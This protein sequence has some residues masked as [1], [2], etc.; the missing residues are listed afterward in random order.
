MRMS[1]FAVLSAAAAS[2]LTAAA[3]ISGVGTAVAA[4][5]KPAEVAVPGSSPAFTAHARVIGNV[6]TTRQLSIQFWLKPRSTA[7][8][9][10]A[11]A[12]STPG[13]ALFHHYLSPDQYTARFGPTAGQA[14][15]VE[16][17]LRG[18][19]F[20]D[21]Q[22]DAQRDYV[23]ATAP[24]ATINR[25]LHVT[26]KL[27][28]PSAGVS[29]GHYTL[30][31][32]DRPVILPSSVA[33]DVLGITGLDNAAV[34]QPLMAR[35]ASTAGKAACSQYFGQHKVSG[36]P[37]RFGTSTFY[38]FNCGY[39]AHQI[40]GAYG[41]NTRNTG[42]GQTVALVDLGLV[43]D[44]FLTLSDWAKAYHLPRPSASRYEQIGLGRVSQCG[45]FDVEEQLDVEASYAMAPAA[46]QIVMGADSCDEGDAG[47]Q[48][49]FNADIAVLNGSGDQPLATIT[50]NSWGISRESAPGGTLS[51]A[52][53]Y[54]VRAAAEGVGMYFAS[55][56]S[57]GVEFPTDPYSI[58][59]GATSLGLGKDGQ[60]LFETGWSTGL[61]FVKNGT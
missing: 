59:V 36:L 35:P 58:S 6:A 49:L 47:L 24:A 42:K 21:V 43:Q 60:R 25:A 31:A 13:T 22:T 5:P 26:L 15:V 48:G 50:S 55:G 30:Y 10:Y 40:R 41:M 54:L 16:S 17:W 38:T 18:Q 33:P 28:R 51:V 3:L 52:H 19:K 61:Q 29:G 44:M 11:N 23:R 2:V 37:K 56:D 32:N 8:E 53:A 12:V 7:A 4:A 57:Q 39:T 27:Y 46:R 1:R 34:T 14:A 9:Q 45:T 20:S